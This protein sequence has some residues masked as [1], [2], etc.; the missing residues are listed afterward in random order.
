MSYVESW[1]LAPSQVYADVR[2]DGCDVALEPAEI[3]L[4]DAQGRWNVLIPKDGLRLELHG[5]FGALID[6]IVGRPSDVTVLL[7][8]ECGL[9]LGRT[10]PAIAEK[11][12]NLG[13]QALADELGVTPYWKAQE[14][15]EA[16]EDQ[17]DVEEAR[18]ALAASR[19]KRVSFEEVAQD[20]QFRHLERLKRGE[21]E[22][23]D[24]DA[25]EPPAGRRED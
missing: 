22:F 3:V 11:L 1:A 25:A 4:V 20:L 9:R 24:V 13:G 14:L 5:G 17:I 18:K 16:L 19:G 8:R 10:F 15:D 7:C 23:G 12:A 6:R 2:C 21:F